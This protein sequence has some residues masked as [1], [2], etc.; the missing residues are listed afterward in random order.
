MLQHVAVQVGLR[1][2]TFVRSGL[3]VTGVVHHAGVQLQ[4]QAAVFLV[5][6]D[7]AQFHILVVQGDGG[8]VVLLFLGFLVHG[9]AIVAHAAH[10]PPPEVDAG[11]PVQV[12]NNLTLEVGQYAEHVSAHAIVIHVFGAAYSGKVT[13]G[14]EGVILHGSRAVETPE[15]IQRVAHISDGSVY[16]HVGNEILGVVCQ[17]ET[18]TVA[19][20]EVR[21]F[22]ADF[23]ER[24]RIGGTVSIIIN[25]T[26]GA[27]LEAVVLGIS[28]RG[29]YAKAPAFL[30][31]FLLLLCRCSDA[32]KQQHNTQKLFH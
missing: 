15:R 23:V 30:H 27:G 13:V 28:G 25:V 12:R 6:L 3:D 29:Q 26:E 1:P 22:P 4:G 16:T 10:S 9:N 20:G 21:T 17:I 18:H 11:G 2:N 31:F 32:R 7:S 19:I 5:R 14:P 24:I 8:V